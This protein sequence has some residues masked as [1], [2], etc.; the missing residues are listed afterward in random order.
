MKLDDGSGTGGQNSDC[1]SKHA[2]GESGFDSRRRHRSGMEHR[3]LP[4]LSLWRTQLDHAGATIKA[5]HGARINDVSHIPELQRAR[6]ALSTASRPRPS[7]LRLLGRDVPGR[8][9]FSTG[10]RL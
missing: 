3:C 4:S 2:L 6:P 7:G 10:A 5:G 8:H 1:V 9:A